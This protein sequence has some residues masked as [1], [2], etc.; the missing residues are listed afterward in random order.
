[1]KITLELLERLKSKR[2]GYTRNALQLLGVSW[3]PPRGWRRKLVNEA[4]QNMAEEAMKEPE[5]EPETV[6][7][8]GCGLIF[9]H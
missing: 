8:P 9:R 2:G 3:P 6:A 7:C 5:R 4:K 1:M